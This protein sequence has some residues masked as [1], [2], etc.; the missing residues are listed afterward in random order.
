MALLKQKTA[1]A[2]SLLLLG[3]LRVEALALE[4]RHDEYAVKAAFLYNFARFVE[5]P[6]TTFRKQTDPFVTCVLGADPFGGTLEE[7][8]K[9]K[10]VDGRAFRI[11]RIADTS[12]AA[13]CQILFISS[14]EHKRTAAIIATLPPGTLTVGEMDGFSAAGGIINFT[15]NEGHVRFEVN[16]RAAERAGLQISSRLLSLAQI[17]DR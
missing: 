9:G 3:S 11:L 13:A 6:S 15:L 16:R 2:L 5:W 8:L 10:Q 17:V 4:A 7:I 12:E 1:F 14:S